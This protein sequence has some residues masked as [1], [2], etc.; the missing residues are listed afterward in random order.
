MKVYRRLWLVVCVPLS[1]VGASIAFA[2]SPVA[3]TFLFIY[4]GALGMLMTLGFVAEYWEL[5]S[6][7]RMRLLAGGAVV[8]GSAACSFIGFAS[9]LGPG[10]FLL[11]VLVLATSPYAVRTYRRWLGVAQQTKCLET[12]ARACAYA[13]P[14]YVS[15]PEIDLSTLTD[16]QLCYRWRV[17]YLALLHSSA[18][19]MKETVVERERYLDEFERRNRSGFAAWLASG[20]LASAN[21]MP[22]LVGVPTINWDDLTREQES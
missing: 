6:G 4:F 17:S 22:Y 1:A 7:G 18:G 15:R 2:K 20:P 8:G 13:H 19:Q 5:D 12:L 9:L 14:H 3:V 21:P 16:E 10:V 11:A